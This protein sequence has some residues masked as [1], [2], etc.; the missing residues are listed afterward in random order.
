MKIQIIICNCYNNFVLF[1]FLL[2][3]TVNFCTQTFFSLKDG[4][5]T[6]EM[7]FPEPIIAR[8][9]RILPTACS[10]S[11]VMKLEVLG[12]RLTDCPL[13]KFVGLSTRYLG[14]RSDADRRSGS[15]DHYATTRPRSEL[16][17]VLRDSGPGLCMISNPAI[18]ACSLCAVWSSRVTR[19]HIESRSGFWIQLIRFQCQ[20]VFVCRGEGVSCKGTA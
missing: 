1:F 11:C 4:N 2:F 17:A 18:N 20:K 3:V 6:V 9:L 15:K 12:V 16:R 19:N 10:G 13:G 8:Y 5:V 7:L 14:S